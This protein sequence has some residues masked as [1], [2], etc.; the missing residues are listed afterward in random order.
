[1]SPYREPGR[2]QEKP[3][4]R[5]VTSTRTVVLTL[6]VASTAAALIAARVIPIGNIGPGELVVIALIAGLLLG[7]GRIAETGNRALDA[8]AIWWRG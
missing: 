7:A 3:R 8:L 6:L 1:M 4:P 2:R 5:Q